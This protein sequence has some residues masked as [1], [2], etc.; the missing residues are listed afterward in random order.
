MHSIRVKVK[1]K[2]ST[3]LTKHD[4]MKTHGA[5]EVYLHTFLT[6]T[7]DGDL[8]NHKQCVRITI[9]TETLP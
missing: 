3:C 6:S 4:A 9:L 8:K 1:V 7:L 5:V 2:L